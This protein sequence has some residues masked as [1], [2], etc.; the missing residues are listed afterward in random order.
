MGGNIFNPN[1]GGLQ[2]G[3]SQLDK[4]KHKIMQIMG[5]YQ[6]LF[7][8]SDTVNGQKIYFC[9]GINVS[10]ALQ[11]VSFTCSASGVYAK[12][13]ITL[14]INDISCDFCSY[15]VD[16]GIIIRF[17]TKVYVWET[18]DGE[19]Y[20]KTTSQMILYRF[21]TYIDGSNGADKLK[22]SFDELIRLTKQNYGRK[23]I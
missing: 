10:F 21:Y 23:H 3:L 4:V 8:P 7:D 22:A 5:H 13:V 9:Q 12:C 6:A 11:T 16:E 14:N 20:E 1:N 15:G 17:P 2:G 18:N 19:K